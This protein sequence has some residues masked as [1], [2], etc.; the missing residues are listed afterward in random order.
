MALPKPNEAEVRRILS[1]AWSR[2]RRKADSQGVHNAIEMDLNR[3]FEDRYNGSTKYFFLMA[4][5]FVLLIYAVSQTI[6]LE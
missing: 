5:L 3:E 6:G 1:R 2:R 4:V